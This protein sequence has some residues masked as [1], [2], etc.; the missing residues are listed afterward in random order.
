MSE[1]DLLLLGILVVVFVGQTFIVGLLSSILRQ[2]QTK[3]SQP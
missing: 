3:E 1:T 2:L